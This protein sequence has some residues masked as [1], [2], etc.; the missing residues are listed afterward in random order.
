MPQHCSLTDAAAS[1]LSQSGQ[2]TRQKRN[3]EASNDDGI[4]SVE[5]HCK[6]EHGTHPGKTPL[7]YVNNVRY[8]SNEYVTWNFLPGGLF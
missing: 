5:E 4:D 2:A 7:A 1:T 8:T 6:P 3:F